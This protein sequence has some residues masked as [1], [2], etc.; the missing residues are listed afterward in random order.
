MS[1]LKEISSNE[2]KDGIKEIGYY[3]IEYAYKHL[4]GKIL[5]IIDASI[6]D[7]QQL[8]AIKDLIKRE[9]FIEIDKWQN[10]YW[11]GKEGHSVTLGE[12]QDHDPLI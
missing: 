4:A 8:K 7:K 2:N 10:T 3:S 9:F 5:T 6:G 1:K 12:L 11:N